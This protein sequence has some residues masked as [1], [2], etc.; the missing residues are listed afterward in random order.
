MQENDA[1]LV[2]IVEIDDYIGLRLRPAAPLW[3][4]KNMEGFEVSVEQL[5]PLSVYDQEGVKIPLS[6]LWAAQTA[7]LVFVRHFG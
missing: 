1:A 7:A 2:G 5:A 4:Q 6:D 3:R